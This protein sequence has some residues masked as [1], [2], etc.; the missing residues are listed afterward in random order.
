MNTFAVVFLCVQACLVQSVFSQCTS[1]AAVA[2]DPSPYG[3]A[4]P[5]ALD[6]CAGWGGMAAAAPFGY[7]AGIADIAYPGLAAPYAGLAGP[8]AGL[9]GPY[10]GLAAPYGAAAPYGGA[11][12]GNVAVAGELPV[13]GSTAVAG[14]VPIMGAVKF[15]G[16]VAAAGAVSIAGQC[17]CGC[18]APYEYLY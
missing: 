13:A 14:Q 4:G 18:G 5:L 8:Y 1:R 7:R 9:A 6:G 15:G 3:L 12:E 10:T 2:A 17:A 16:D 11:G